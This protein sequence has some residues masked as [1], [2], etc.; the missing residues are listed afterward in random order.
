MMSRVPNVRLLQTRN[1]VLGHYHARKVPEF[2]IRIA[3]F[4]NSN[5]FRGVVKKAENIYSAYLGSNTMHRA[6]R[7]QL[8]H[9]KYNKKLI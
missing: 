8:A 5:I 4:S 7:P 2:A 3:R 1:E 6:V 9:I